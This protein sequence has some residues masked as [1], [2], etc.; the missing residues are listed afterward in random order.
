M[1][2][3]F[4]EGKIIARGGGVPNNIRNNELER[5]PGKGENVPCFVRIGCHRLLDT[6]LISERPLMGWKIVKFSNAKL[7]IIPFGIKFSL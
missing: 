2:P 7:L 5:Q 1:W 3:T 6:V 4:V